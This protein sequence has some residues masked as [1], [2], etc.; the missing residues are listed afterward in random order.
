MRNTSPR[1]RWATFGGGPP[2]SA[3]ELGE[4]PARHHLLQ[5][6]RGDQLHLPSASE[7]PPTATVVYDDR[8]DLTSTTGACRNGMTVSAIPVNGAITLSLR[9][10]FGATTEAIDIGAIGIVYN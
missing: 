4:D 1:T 7:D 10:N 8:T 6:R 5:G 9:L 3:A 2:A